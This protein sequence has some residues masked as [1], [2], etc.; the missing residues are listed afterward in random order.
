MVTSD[1]RDQLDEV[2]KVA[3]EA[4]HEALEKGERP[5]EDARVRALLDR[6]N[7]LRRKLGLVS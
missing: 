6:A 5:S 4:I 7:L 2:L 1:D 3:M